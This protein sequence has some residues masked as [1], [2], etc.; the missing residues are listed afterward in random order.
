LRIFSF[1]SET[2]SNIKSSSRG[3]GAGVVVPD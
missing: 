1:F 2:G 3:M